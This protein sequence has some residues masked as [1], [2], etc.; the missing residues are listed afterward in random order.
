MQPG[1]TIRYA[2]HFSQERKVWLEGNAL[3]EVYKHQGST[4][5]VYLN[6]AFIEVK[7][8]CFLV[9][10]DKVTQNEI[11]LFNGRIDFNIETT[12]AKTELYPLHKI[13][14]NSEK[15]ETRVQTIANISWE[16]GR[17]NFTDI[18]LPQ[19]I[20]TINQMYDTNIIL[21]GNMK[22]ESAFTGSIRYG[23]PLEDV[24]D[25]VCFTLNLHQEEKDNQIIICD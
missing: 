12:G 22:K 1:S 24:L 21:K 2:R 7:G 14:Y 18:P 19:L 15:A 11:T 9:K 6:K 13:I 23:E 3:F 25:K 5:R 20:Q 10:Q 16:N 4:F 8:T 17:Y